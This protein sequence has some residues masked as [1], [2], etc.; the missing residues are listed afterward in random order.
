[1]SITGFE[2]LVVVVKI[3]SRSEKENLESMRDEYEEKYRKCLQRF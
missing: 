1:M 2:V 3:D